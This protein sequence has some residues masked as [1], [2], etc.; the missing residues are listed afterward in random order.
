M[1]AMPCTVSVIT[2]N[3]LCTLFT[4]CLGLLLLNTPLKFLAVA[5]VLQV[6]KN[7]L[8]CPLSGQKSSAICVTT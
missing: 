3:G 2:C 5:I 8:P 1:D 6:P 4:V 7:N